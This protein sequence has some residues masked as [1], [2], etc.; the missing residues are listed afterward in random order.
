MSKSAYNFIQQRLS[1]SLITIK[2]LNKQKSQD[3]LFGGFNHR[4]RFSAVIRSPA[5][6]KM[7]EAWR[8]I[9]FLN[10]RNSIDFIET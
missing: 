6:W 9:P 5:N 7:P 8:V 1:S 10:F 3:V 2:M 4:N